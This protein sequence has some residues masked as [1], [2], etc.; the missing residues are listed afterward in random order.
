[1]KM[2]VTE[3]PRKLVESSFAGHAASPMKGAYLA[4]ED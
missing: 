3:E 4:Y 2:T 1:M